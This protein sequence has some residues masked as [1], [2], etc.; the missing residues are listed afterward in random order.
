MLGQRPREDDFVCRGR[1][2]PKSWWATLHGEEQLLA[3]VADNLVSLGQLDWRLVSIRLSGGDLT[4][5][6]PPF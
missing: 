6:Q 1:R 2:P 5:T 3:G 4:F